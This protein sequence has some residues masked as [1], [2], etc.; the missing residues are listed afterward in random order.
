MRL[1]RAAPLLTRGRK[2]AA[3]DVLDDHVGR[4]LELAEVEDVEDVRVA[5]VRDRLRLA[6]EPRG[7][8]GIRCQPLQDLD[9]AD[10]FE[11]GVVG[12]IDH[13]HGTLADEV[14]DY[15]R[16]QLGSG[17]DRHGSLIMRSGSCV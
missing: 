13:A 4:S 10:A 15:V 5:H 2:A 17:R 11:L 16:T 6:A 3:L 9:R 7:R 12:A 1:R 14:L 8:V